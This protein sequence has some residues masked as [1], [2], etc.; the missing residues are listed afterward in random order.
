MRRRKRKANVKVLDERSRHIRTDIWDDVDELAGFV[1]DLDLDD[2]AKN[3]ILEGV[4]E[5]ADLATALLNY[6]ELPKKIRYPFNPK[7]AN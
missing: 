6:T 2:D 5:L 7:D 3:Y 1:S 4:N